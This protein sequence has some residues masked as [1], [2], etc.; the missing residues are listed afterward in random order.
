MKTKYFPSEE[1]LIQEGK[2]KDQNSMWANC[3]YCETTETLFTHED[4]S[5]EL[6]NRWLS[7]HVYFNCI[8]RGK[9]V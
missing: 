5:D 6:A 9:H 8:K 1:W 2:F 3:G 4:N 7:D